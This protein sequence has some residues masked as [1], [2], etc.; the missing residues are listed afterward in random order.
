M[1]H[2]IF[3]ATVMPIL[4][5]NVSLRLDEEE[6][7]LP[8]KAA[9]ALGI[10]RDQI[11]E[12]RIVRKSL[13][14]RKK[15]RIHFVYSLAVSLPHE[16][17]QK[18][19]ASQFPDVSPY[20]ENPPPSPRPVSKKS[21]NRPVIVGTGP[22]GLFAALTFCESGWPPL[23]LERGR[24]IPERIKDVKRFWNEGSLNPESNVQF[25]EGGA[26]TFSDGKLYTRLHDPRIVFILESFCKF[27][28][29]EEILYLQRPHIGTDRLRQT[30]MALR[31]HLI[32][33]GAEFRFQTRLTEIE[34]SQG[35]LQ[36]VVTNDSDRLPA[37]ILLL[38][39]GNGARDTFQMLN[40]SGLTL[41]PKPFAIG[42][43][44]E[45][46]QKFIDKSQYGPSAGHSR[47]PPSEYQLSFRS[48]RGR[49][50]YS[51]CM[52]PGGW[53]IGASSEPG[54]LVTNGMSLLRRDSP[55]ANS[56]LVV[57]VG[58][59]DFPE[60]SALAGVDFQKVWEEKAFRLGGGQFKAPAQRLP[61][62]LQG[63]ISK[64]LGETS[65]KPGVIPASLD[66]CLPSFVVEDLREA[67]PFFNR[68]VA[69]FSSEAAVLIG[70]ETRT[71]SP[72][73]IVRG[74]DFQS[75]AV[76]GIYPC[77]EGSG[78]AGGIISSALDGIKAVESILK[79]RA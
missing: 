58:P 11:Q 2:A 48:S 32:E 60:K 40:R 57:G 79:S 65:F 74:E 42:L 59:A 66:R 14:A 47:L 19:L 23:I 63:R 26:G 62:F 10:A 70:V 30:V 8:F 75:A 78:Y 25:G 12:F 20:E 37:S 68:K 27:G 17:E 35:I 44:V 18:A 6:N 50:V 5:K 43:R 15:N 61:D 76:K 56:A 69:G 29:P 22:A 36:G 21:E 1:R 39:V 45:H 71:S 41:E 34:I 4:L 73:R 24:E 13:D 38:A 33:Q 7:R 51:F 9:E 16:E 67:I 72:I 64:S 52:C 3:D 28:A 54:R 46:P 53:V 31:K 49:G 77:G 55:W